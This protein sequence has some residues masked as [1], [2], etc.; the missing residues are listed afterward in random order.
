MQRC[1]LLDD[2]GLRGIP[3]ASEQAMV[4]VCATFRADGL[5]GKRETKLTL[6]R[7]RETERENPKCLKHAIC[8]WW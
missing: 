1:P 6:N 5:M 3:L 2:C 8:Q 4:D 7:G